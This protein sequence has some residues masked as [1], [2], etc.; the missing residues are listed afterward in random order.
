MKILIFFEDIIFKYFSWTK[1]HDQDSNEMIIQKSNQLSID[2][3][4]NNH[5][6][7]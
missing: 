5:F 3:H 2:D 1:V 6:Q 4:L 7:L